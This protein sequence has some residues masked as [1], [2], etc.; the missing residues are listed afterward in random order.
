MQLAH[1]SR[2][3]FKRQP[4]KKDAL[5]MRRRGPC[6]EKARRGLQSCENPAQ[7]KQK[8]TKQERGRGEEDKKKVTV[9]S[10]GI[11][12]KAGWLPS[13]IQHV[14]NNSV[15]EAMKV[16]SQASWTDKQEG[17][18]HSQKTQLTKPIMKHFTLLNCANT[19]LCLFCEDDRDK[20]HNNRPGKN[21]QFSLAFAAVDSFW[22]FARL[23]G[24]LTQES[25]SEIEI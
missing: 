9:V 20:M 6:S 4:E 15:T 5:L 14:V 8:W 22:L 21:L 10:E 1:V 19:L 2:R 3:Q 16:F 7:H 13:S 11:R 25:L 17:R 24:C 12:K 18:Y 23:V